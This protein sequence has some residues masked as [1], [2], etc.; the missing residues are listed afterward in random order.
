[1][2]LLEEPGQDLV[3]AVKKFHNKHDLNSI[4]LKLSKPDPDGFNTMCH[5]DLW[6]NN[7]LFK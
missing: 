2:Q 4:T 7:M 6:F 5:G 1:M 3:T